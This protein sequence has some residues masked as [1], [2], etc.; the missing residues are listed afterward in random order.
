MTCVDLEDLSAQEQGAILVSVG[1]VISKNNIKLEDFS[2]DAIEQHAEELKEE[3]LKE[4][5]AG[6]R[7]HELLRKQV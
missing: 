4:G 6:E 3:L 2:D 7:A 1:R 5:I